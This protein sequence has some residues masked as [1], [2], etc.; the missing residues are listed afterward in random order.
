M[1]GEGRKYAYD[2]VD[3]RPRPGMTFHE[4]MEDIKR[5][6]FSDLRGY[7]GIAVAVV[8]GE[9]NGMDFK[10]FT[11]SEDPGSF[12]RYVL[13]GCQMEGWLR[14]APDEN[15]LAT[16]AG[17]ERAKD[18]AAL[19]E[20]LF[21]LKFDDYAGIE[22]LCA[23]MTQGWC[24]FLTEDAGAVFEQGL[25]A[26]LLWI[27]AVNRFEDEIGLENT[28]LRRLGAARIQSLIE[29]GRARRR[30]ELARA[31]TIDIGCFRTMKEADA[32]MNDCV[33]AFR[34]GLLVEGLGFFRSIHPRALE[35][36]IEK[37]VVAP[38]LPRPRPGP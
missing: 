27:G 3:Y 13:G 16:C 38:R 34:D 21:R 1:A 9:R 28:P 37:L 19:K 17:L 23:A 11:S 8:L 22:S 30:E 7:E 18:M 31:E 32:L 2:C 12:Y 33:R 6:V 29:D 5:T 15:L 26:Q 10:S 25:R 35:P 36:H 14:C 24:D 20:K 4:I